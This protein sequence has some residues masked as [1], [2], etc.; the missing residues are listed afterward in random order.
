MMSNMTTQIKVRVS[1]LTGCI[2][3]YRTS[4]SA[5]E[6]ND[7]SVRPSD[8]SVSCCLFADGE[9]LSLPSRT[10][11]KQA[12]LEGCEWQEWLQYYIKVS[13]ATLNVASV[14]HAPHFA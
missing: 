4:C 3:T 14:K 7:R 13:K 9:A 10:R 6:D 2:Q 8:L 11:P 12:N 5:S 1:L